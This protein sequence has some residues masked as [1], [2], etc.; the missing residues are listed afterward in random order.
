MPNYT[1]NMSEGA[2]SADSGIKNA[3]TLSPGDLKVTYYY[4]PNYGHFIVDLP[5]TVDAGI[6]AKTSVWAEIMTAAPEISLIIGNATTNEV[7]TYLITNNN[8]GANISSNKLDQGVLNQTLFRIALDILGYLPIVGYV[9]NTVSLAADLE[10]VGMSSASASILSGNATMYEQYATG[11]GNYSF[12]S[13][14]QAVAWQNI[15]STGAEFK[16]EISAPYDSSHT[17]EVKAYDSTYT[18]SGGNWQGLARYFN[19]SALPAN[20]LYGT[21]YTSTGVP[22]ANANIY[23]ETTTGIA[24]EE[25]TNQYGQYGFFGVP[26]ASYW[27]W[28]NYVTPFGSA[29]STYYEVT[30]NGN[31]DVGGYTLAPDLTIPATYIKGYVYGS[32]GRLSGASVTATI[33]GKSDSATT[34]SNGYYQILTN[35]A[36]TYDMS[37]SHYDYYTGTGSVTVSLSSDAWWNKTLEYH[38]TPP[39][40]CVLF[41]TSITLFNGKTIP[42]QDLTIGKQIL[43]YD[44]SNESLIQG[45]VNGITVSNVSHVWEIDG[46]IGISGVKDQPL[47]VQL[48]NGTEELLPLGELNNTMEIF[49]PLNS[50]WIQV[51]NITVFNGNFTVYDISASPP[52]VFHNDTGIQGDYIANGILVPDKFP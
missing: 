38:A 19:F 10:G 49:D 11:G 43:S 24:Y 36:G 1:S 51:Y 33:S 15:Y 9:A 18:P 42:V 27:V 6:G 8:T 48:Q 45:I 37:A 16:I 25:Q 47:Y 4:D 31:G 32:N 20:E 35:F 7:T 34:N 46:I 41:G 39:P 3:I 50:T 14:G 21:A 2:N 28:G 5:V 17:F 12:N 40:G 22:A 13:N 44:F 29:N 26:G 30:A 52:S 23:I